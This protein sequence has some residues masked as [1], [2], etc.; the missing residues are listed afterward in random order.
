MVPEYIELPG[1][2]QS[3][4]GTQNFDDLPAKALTFV[5]KVENI[6]K[7]KIHYVQ[8]SNDYEDGILRIV[9]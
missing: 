7:T 4:R 8:V 2:K 9:R 6:S 3:L 1:W 5:R